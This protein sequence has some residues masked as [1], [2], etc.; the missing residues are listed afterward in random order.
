MRSDTLSGAYTAKLGRFA[1]PAPCALPQPLVQ[2]APASQSD[3]DA[4]LIAVRRSLESCKDTTQL[5][6]L[7]AFQSPRRMGL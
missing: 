4:L 1:Q 3:A 2:P 5:K 7:V 6:M